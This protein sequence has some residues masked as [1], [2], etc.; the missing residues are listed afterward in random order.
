[1]TTNFSRNGI[2]SPFGKLTAPVGPYKIPEE[3]FDI[4][5][6]EAAKAGLPLNEFLR[7][8]AIVR[9]HGKQAVE[10]VHITRVSVVAGTIEE[11]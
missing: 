1:M 11:S 6:A 10:S 9:A 8:L 7:E 4:L 2:T 5:T 3:T